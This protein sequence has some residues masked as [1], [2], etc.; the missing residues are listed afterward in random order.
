MPGRILCKTV[1]VEN[2]N[3][4][5]WGLRVQVEKA[6]MGRSVIPRMTLCIGQRDTN[7]VSEVIEQLKKCYH[8]VVRDR[9]EPRGHRMSWAMLAREMMGKEFELTRMGGN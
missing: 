8:V 3:D 9:P 5:C 2:T 4:G 1:E 7:D 6:Q